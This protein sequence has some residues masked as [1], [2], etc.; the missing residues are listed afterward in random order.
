M[1]SLVQPLFDGPIDIVG[2]IH[3]EFEAMESLL[4]HLGYDASGRHAQG[5]RLV[6][7]GD[8]TDRGPD[9]PAVVDRVAELVEAGRAQCVLG[10]HD[11]SFLLEEQKFENKWYWGQDFLDEDGKTIAQKLADDEVRRRIRRFFASLPLALE[12]D[13]LRVVHACWADEAIAAARPASDVAALYWLHRQRIENEIAGQ[14]LDEIDC[15]LAHQNRNPVKLLTSGPEE[16]SQ[17]PI[18]V[19]GKSR[20]EKRVAWWRHYN[21]IF[22]VYG[23]YG[24]VDSEPRGDAHS[25]CADFAVGKRWTERRAGVRSNFLHKLAALRCPEWE[26]FFDDGRRV[27]RNPPAQRLS[28]RPSV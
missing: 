15:K 21:D 19:S 17:A 3:G 28:S 2:D 7:L 22:C 16:R 1:P 18:V 8:L 27:Q 10:N 13:D 9:S 24:A 26:I 6:F 14:P 23:H 5:R 11:L 25:F 20:Q 12:R 4:V